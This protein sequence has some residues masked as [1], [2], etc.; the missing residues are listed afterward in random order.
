VDWKLEVV[1][2]PVTD[3]DRAKA[4]YAD[5]V[6]FTV[7]HDTTIS[8]AM[9]IIQLTPPGS[10]CSIVIGTGIPSGPPGS[11]KGIQLVVPDLDA[12][13]AKLSER[14]VDITPIRHNDGG[15]WRDGRGGPWN[16]FA[17]FDDPDGNNWVIQERPAD[18]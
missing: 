15:T 17:F 10:A 13:R 6:G 8:D 1:V 18:Q 12:A 3:L 14:G 2:I 16:A 7:D 5:Q 9:R 4:F 11:V